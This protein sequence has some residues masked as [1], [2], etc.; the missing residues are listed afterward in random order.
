MTPEDLRDF[1]LGL[2]GAQETFPFGSEVSVFKVGGKIFALSS[3]G[4]SP[5]TVS[6]KC[7]PELG[8]ALRGGY[9]DIVPGYHL[10]KRHWITVTLGGDV[11]DR[12]AL[13]LVE[14]SHDLV[15]PRPRRRA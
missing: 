4:A 6:V 13:D 11:P 9:E 8:E 10:N 1:C 14:D 12:Q 3:L 7:E 15:R 5:L 2:A